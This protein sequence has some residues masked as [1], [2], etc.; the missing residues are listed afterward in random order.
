VQETHARLGLDDDAV[1]DDDAQLDDA[2]A[3]R[4][5]GAEVERRRRQAVPG[6]ERQPGPDREHRLVNRHGSIVADARAAPD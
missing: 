6:R 5:G 3:R 1:L 2:V 4:V